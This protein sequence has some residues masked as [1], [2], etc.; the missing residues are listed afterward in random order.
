M[1]LLCTFGLIFSSYF[2]SNFF[3]TLTLLKKGEPAVILPIRE[4]GRYHFE[5]DI[6]RSSENVNNDVLSLKL[7]IH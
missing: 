4:G 3:P 2:F 5:K 6:Y 1:T 7:F